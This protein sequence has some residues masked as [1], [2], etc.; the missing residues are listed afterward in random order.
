VAVASLL[1][2]VL[3]GNARLRILTSVS[4]VPPPC[5]RRTQ[6]QVSKTRPAGGSRPPLT[7]R[8]KL[9]ALHVL[10]EWEQELATGKGF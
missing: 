5:N 1:G 8:P 4:R 9:S 6:Q 3:F 7:A 10:S 2:Y